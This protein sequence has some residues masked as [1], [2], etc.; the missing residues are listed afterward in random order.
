MSI[1]LTSELE[2]AGTLPAALLE[3][4]FSVAYTSHVSPPT[5]SI[6]LDLPP[7][8]TSPTFPSQAPK[9]W[10]GVGRAGEGWATPHAAR[11]HMCGWTG[12]SG[13]DVEAAGCVLGHH[14]LV[15]VLRV[16]VRNGRILQGGDQNEHRQP[17]S[18][19]TCFPLSGLTEVGG[20]MTHRHTQ[21]QTSKPP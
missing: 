20:K 17:R 8:P 4:E 12:T 5:I 1:P 13:G 16:D 9:T 21:I 7:S 10:G 19:Q 6:L 11:S 3:R 14:H 18:G 2:P 15:G